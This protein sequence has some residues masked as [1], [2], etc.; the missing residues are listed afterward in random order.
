[1]KK[2]LALI[3]ALCLVFA[4][5]G[6]GSEPTHIRGEQQSNTSSEETL[7]LGAVD[8]LTYENKFIGI[9]CKLS[10][11]WAFYTDEEIR[12]L[13]NI[14]ADVMGE[15]FQEAIE[16]ATIV[17]DMYA[18][19]ANGDTVNVN[20]EKASALQ[21]LSLDLNE[22]YKAIFDEIK[23][24]FE[25]QGFS[26]VAYE[27]G[28]VNFSGKEFPCINITAEYMG[29]T[30]YETLLSIKC[31]GYLANMAVASLDKS[32]LDATLASFYTVEK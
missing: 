25:S 23:P 9:G 8:G 2:L 32:V 29:L 19:T 10:D 1:M 12:E 17:Y 27:L 26:N 15:E 18:S 3:L 14:T 5:A 24:S 4:F 22:N 11:E 30:M 21:L 20:L 28:S 31:S 6:C 13:N 16:I 7:S